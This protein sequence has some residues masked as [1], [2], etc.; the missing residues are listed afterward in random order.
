[1]KKTIF[2][3][4]MTCLSLILIYGQGLQVEHGISNVFDGTGGLLWV[5]Q[6][7]LR[8]LSLDEDEIQA[9][10]DI[11][12]TSLKINQH[13]GSIYMLHQ[14]STTANLAIDGDGMYYVN[15]SDRLGLSTNSPQETL[16]VFGNTR[17]FGLKLTGELGNDDGIIQSTEGITSD[18]VLRSNDNIR[19]DLDKNNDESG[20]F[21]VFSGVNNRVFNL[22]ETDGIDV[23]GNRI[24]VATL[25][26]SKSI[27]L[28]TIGNAVSVDAI[29]ANLFLT[30]A[31]SSNNIIVAPQGASQVG[32]GVTNPSYKLELPNSST[33]SAGQIRANGYAYYSDKR[34]KS[35]FQDVENATDIIMKLSPMT[36]THYDSEIKNGEIKIL[37]SK[38]MQTVGFVAQDMYKVLPDLVHKPDNEKEDLWSIDYTRM[39][40]YLTKALQEQQA[41]IEELKRE[42]KNFS[43]SDK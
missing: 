38:T 17:T 21:E 34:I 32:I 42:M 3:S 12:S 27:Q 43:N 22:S 36:Y 14:G 39:I 18:I 30:T 4:I 9:R 26:N 13:G 23:L 41:I 20:N 28:N 6:K 1:M 35:N 24:R 16:D 10:Y 5:G 8:H 25:N 37:K 19:F 11:V 31:N 29:N 15:S 33:S 7:S 40:P 2:T